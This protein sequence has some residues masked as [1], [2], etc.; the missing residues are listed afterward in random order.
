MTLV[1]AIA[2]AGTGVVYRAGLK[3]Y[4]KPA[5]TMADRTHRDIRY[6]AGSTD[7]MQQLNLFVPER[8]DFATV[9]FVHGGNWDEGD[10][11]YVFHGADIYNNIGR[12]LAS[13]GYGAAVISYRLLPTVDW[14]RQAEDVE[15]A[16]A[17]VHSHAEQ[18]GGR[19]D[20]IVVMGH[21]AGAQLAL[22]VALDRT[23]MR[24]LGVPDDAI[25]GFVGVAGAGYDMTDQETYKLGNSPEWYAE[26]FR[27][28]PSDG[29]WQRNASP[30]QLIAAGAPRTLIMHAGGEDKPLTRQS[31]LLQQRLEA[32][33]T[34]VTFVIA[35]GLSHTRIVPTLSRADR[36]AGAAVLKFL[37]Q[38]P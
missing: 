13:E 10:K 29:D 31:Q 38:L 6:V 12:F 17:W 36:P 27:L 7:A 25:A 35:P 37:R 14:P 20:R 34:S 28:N 23:S 33:G 4:Y 22:R 3:L 1:S 30:S 24:A 5:S 11:D 18:F 9:V 19:P 32:V 21:S 15:R 2:A 26:R 8:P 16:V